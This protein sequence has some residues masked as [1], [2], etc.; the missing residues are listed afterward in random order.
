MAPQA[1][2]LV[3]LPLDASGQRQRTWESLQEK[4]TSL[5]VNAKLELP[6]LR[7]GTLDT[8]MQLSDDLSKT[9]QLME[10]VVAKL[11]RQVG[12][13]GGSEAVSALRVGGAAVEQFLMRFR[14][15]EAKYQAKRPLKEL[16]EAIT[17]SVARIDDDLKA[18][19]AAWP[20]STPRSHAGRMIP[21][22]APRWGWG[23]ARMPQSVPP[24]APC[25]LM[26]DLTYRRTHCRAGQG[27]G[28]QQHEGAAERGG[29]QGWRQPGRARHQRRREAP[30]SGRVREHVHR[31]RGGWQALGQGVGDVVR[32]DVQLRGG[33]WRR[34]AR[35][36]NSPHGAMRDAPRMQAPARLRT[37]AART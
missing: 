32:E 5:S 9:N 16:V 13:L 29:A 34:N 12:E 22:C 28:L 7:V 4:T 17:E 14:W 24:C 33:C 26:P 10:A 3:S 25:M 2:W 31:V 6:E 20:P 8:L 23:D 37:A 11:R 18:S 21:P 30:P 27:G 35:P 15:N 19:G 36:C 1:F